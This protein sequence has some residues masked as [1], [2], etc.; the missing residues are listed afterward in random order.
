MSAEY[1]LVYEEP[2]EPKLIRGPKV[3]GAISHP[4][5]GR[6]YIYMPT[7]DQAEVI[8][9]QIARL[10]GDRPI[11]NDYPILRSLYGNGYGTIV[12]TK[13]GLQGSNAFDEK[14]K[15]LGLKSPIIFEYEVEK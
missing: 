10:Y 6:I 11:M 2:K 13:Q 4:K 8:K 7:D 1:A 15:E 5:P 14:I 12:P 9:K 3:I